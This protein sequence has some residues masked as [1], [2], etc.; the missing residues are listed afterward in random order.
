MNDFQ[1]IGLTVMIISAMIL[2]FIGFK[3]Y[4]VT[5]LEEKK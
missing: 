4:Q 5:N 1:Y 3:I 2:G